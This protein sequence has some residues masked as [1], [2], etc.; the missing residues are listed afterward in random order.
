MN[1][2]LTPAVIGRKET[3]GMSCYRQILT[4]RCGR[5]AENLDDSIAEI[6][7]GAVGAGTDEVFECFEHCELVGRGRRGDRRKHGK[8][9]RIKFLPGATGGAGAGKESFGRNTY[10][11]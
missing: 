3:Y 1:Y 10:V 9:I 6:W 4:G 7:S 2:T 11:I 5:A 8:T